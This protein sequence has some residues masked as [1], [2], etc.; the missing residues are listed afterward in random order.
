MKKRRNSD[1][2]MAPLHKESR[3]GAYFSAA[4]NT[5]SDG[6]RLKAEKFRKE[7]KIMKEK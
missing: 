7:I 5:L 6:G 4:L 3:S 2:L 1:T